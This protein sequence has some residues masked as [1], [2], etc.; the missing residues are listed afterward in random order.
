M[1]EGSIV[2]EGRQERRGVIGQKACGGPPTGTK[3]FLV[4]GCA[5]FVGCIS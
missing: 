1:D 3:L 4:R 5:R 2:E